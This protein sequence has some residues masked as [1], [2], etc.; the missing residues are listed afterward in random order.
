MVRGRRR[1]WSLLNPWNLLTVAKQ[2]VDRGYST[3]T[4][5]TLSG[6]KKRLVWE[7]VNL[8]EGSCLEGNQATFSANGCE[9][10]S[11]NKWWRSRQYISSS[12]MLR[13][14][15]RSNGKAKVDTKLNWDHK[16]AQRI[17]PECLK[18]AVFYQADSNGYICW[19]TG[20][21]GKLPIGSG[22]TAKFSNW[23]SCNL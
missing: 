14:R 16:S 9:E 1:N 12:R 5:A 22:W 19:S 7:V 10:E 2:Q 11:G 6:Y 8:A 17:L 3:A 23:S 4:S 18:V 15:Q 20:R 21:S 13:L